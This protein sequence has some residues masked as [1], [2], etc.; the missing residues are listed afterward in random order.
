MLLEYLKNIWKYSRLRFYVLNATWNYK[1]WL[2]AKKMYKDISYQIE[3]GDYDMDFDY[4]LK[5]EKRV[6]RKK[7]FVGY[8]FENNIY[9]DNPGIQVKDRKTWEIWKKKKLIN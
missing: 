7:R 4:N 3:D 2:F 5:R 8:F 9:F 1:F 6:I